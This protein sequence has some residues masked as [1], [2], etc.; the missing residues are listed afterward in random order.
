MV[1]LGHAY[2]YN[3]LYYV[4]DVDNSTNELRISVDLASRSYVTVD[5]LTAVF[6]YNDGAMLGT[7]QTVVVTVSDEISQ[8]ACSAS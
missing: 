3:F 7:T 4:H 6:F 2:L 5:R 1:Q 8:R